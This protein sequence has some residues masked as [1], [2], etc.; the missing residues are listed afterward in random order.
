M[1]NIVLAF[2]Y[3]IMMVVAFMTLVAGMDSGNKA[4]TRIGVVLAIIWG[5]WA[6]AH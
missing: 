3:I 1:V 2:I 6:V 4:I 5:I